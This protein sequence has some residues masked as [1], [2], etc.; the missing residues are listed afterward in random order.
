MAVTDGKGL[1]QKTRKLAVKTKSGVPVA[2]DVAVGDYAIIKDSSGGTVNLCYND[3]GT[4]KKVA[5]V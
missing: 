5:L 3:A 1:E 4:L 2:A